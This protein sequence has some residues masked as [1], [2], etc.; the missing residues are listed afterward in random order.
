MKSY[1]GTEAFAIT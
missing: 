1:N